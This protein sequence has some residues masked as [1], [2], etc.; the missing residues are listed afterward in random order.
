[1]ISMGQGCGDPH[2][3]S[4]PARARCYPGKHSDEKTS[5]SDSRKR[6][7]FT[8]KYNASDPSSQLSLG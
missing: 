7:F 3:I 4:V 8:S 1:V 6:P 5:D 2:A